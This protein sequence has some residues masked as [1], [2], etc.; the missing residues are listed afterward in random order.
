MLRSGD[1]FEDF[2]GGLGPDEGF[3]VGIVVFQIFHDGALELCDAAERAASDA[4]SGDPAKKR[5]TM[6]SQDAEVGVKW[7]R[8][9]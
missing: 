3:W 7:R 5:S 6:L 9:R 8:K 1:L 2:A 4:F